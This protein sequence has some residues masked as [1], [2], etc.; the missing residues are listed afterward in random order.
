MIAAPPR[1]RSALRRIQLVAAMLSSILVSAPA[2]ATPVTTAANIPFSGISP[3]G[4]DMATGELILV[5]RPDLV[6]E[7]PIPLV[8]RRYYAS[9]L[10]REGLASSAMGPNWLGTYDFTLTQT[11]VVTTFVTN[12]GAAIQFAP[13]SGGSYNL[14]SP[15]YANFKLDHLTDGTWRVTNPLDRRL[16]FFDG[17]FT[18][19][20]IE[21]EHGNSLSLFHPAGGGQLSQVSDGLGRTLTFSYDANGRLA[22]V[23]DGTRTVL[24]GYTGGVLTGVTDAA[25]HSWT[26]AYQTPPQPTAPALLLGAMEPLGNTPV[27]QAYDPLGRVMSQT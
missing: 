7:G 12:R 25:G 6:V 19:T 20:Q 22:Q 1:S 8:F 4:V 5:M 3:G 27:T 11:P 14:V 24:Y 17:S 18:L 15:T 26:Y 10:A 23:S 2:F 21:D 9:M 13:A 16:Y